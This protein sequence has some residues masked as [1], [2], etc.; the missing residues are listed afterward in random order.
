MT[1]SAQRPGGVH[2]FILKRSLDY[3][4]SFPRL[5]RRVGI[6]MPVFAS[7]LPLF[8]LCIGA[9]AVIIGLIADFK[10]FLEVKV[11]FRRPSQDGIK[12]IK[13]A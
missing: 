12:L 9:V 10:D 8:L 11:L 6:P 4:G 3:L 7:I 2:G 1:S 5:P 13:E